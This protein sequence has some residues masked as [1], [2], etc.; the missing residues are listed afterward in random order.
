MKGGAAL[1]GV[2]I[3]MAVMGLFVVNIAQWGTDKGI[4]LA[5]CPNDATGHAMLS[6]AEQD[7]CNMK[8]SLELL[9]VLLFAPVVAFIGIGFIR[10]GAG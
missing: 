3:M 5:D 6:A 10:L 7:A 9:G 8:G 2:F 1:L 4:D